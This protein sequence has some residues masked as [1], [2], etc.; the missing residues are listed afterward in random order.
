MICNS[1]PERC[2]IEALHPNER[3]PGRKVQG[4]AAA[5]LPYEPDGRIAV[6]AFQATS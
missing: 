1:E 3:Q 2:R 4:I 5:L 6:D